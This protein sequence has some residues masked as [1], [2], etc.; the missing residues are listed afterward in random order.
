MIPVRGGVATLPAHSALP[1]DLIYVLRVYGKDGNFDETEAK[2]LTLFDGPA[3]RAVQTVPGNK[4]SGFG[5]D[6]TAIQ[7]ISVKGGSVTVY[8]ENVS[9]GG[10]V[11]ILG[12][13]VPVDSLGQFAVQH[14]LPYGEHSVDVEITQNGQKV[15]SVSYTHLTLPTTPYV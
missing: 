9:Q 6:R 13:S 4:L 12:Q 5:I 10:Q 7:N 2:L 14:I 11:S 3:P 15:V 8:G 1:S